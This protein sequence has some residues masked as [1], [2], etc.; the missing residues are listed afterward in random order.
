MMLGALGKPSK[1][2]PSGLIQTQYVNCWLCQHGYYLVLATSA[3]VLE[4][5]KDNRVIGIDLPGHGKS[6]TWGGKHSW[7][8]YIP[9]VCGLLEQNSLVGTYS[10]AIPNQGRSLLSVYAQLNKRLGN[11]ALLRWY[12]YCMTY[13]KALDWYVYHDD[14]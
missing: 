9:A 13:L 5:C 3:Q 8:R 14:S 2:L 4:L 7:E 1:K 12:N 6:A 10:F 11:R